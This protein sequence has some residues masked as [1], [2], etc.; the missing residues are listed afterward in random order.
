[1]P[2]TTIP[3]S[4]GKRRATYDVLSVPINALTLE[5]AAELVHDLVNQNTKGYVIFAT[6]SSLLAVRD[7]KAVR[8]AFD[9]ATA[10]TPDGMPLVWLGKRTGCQVTRVYGPDL[11]LE[12]LADPQ[13]QLRHFFY[14][15]APGVAA[16]MA[17]RLSDQFPWLQIAG[18]L[19]PGQ[20]S[21]RDVLPEDA[22]VINESGADIVWV[23]LGHPKQELWMHA[24][25]AHLDAP[26]LA[27]VGAAFDF[28]SGN[29]KEAPRWVQKSGLQWMHRLV[30]DPL[31]LW[32]RYLIGNP[33]FAV[34][35]ARERMGNRL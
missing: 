3:D 34:L 28:F 25:R 29:V 30:G 14:G 18:V 21:G 20:V 35:V 6:A 27:G 33:R 4:L 2:S 22:A 19:S 10:V 26:V 15:G 7:D 31:R 1:M 11:M 23:G 8:A 9:D 16:E 13:R 24:H 12:V 32:K 17:T 5:G